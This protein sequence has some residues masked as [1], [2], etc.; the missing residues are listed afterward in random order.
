LIHQVL[1]ERGFAPPGIVFPV[2]SVMAER[3]AT[4]RETL[5]AHTVPLMTHIPWRPTPPGNVEVLADT[6]DV[7]CTFDATACAEFLYACV[8]RT[9]DV[10]MPRELDY[11]RRHDRAMREVRNRVA[12]SDRLAQD[13]IP[14]VHPSP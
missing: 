8:A 9:I 7:D 12:F 13:F 6:A 2:S 10:D 4:Y 11:L 5:R 14:F 3:I 1:A